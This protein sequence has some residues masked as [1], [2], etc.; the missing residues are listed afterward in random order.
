MDGRPLPQLAAIV[1]LLL[2]G[3]SGLAAGLTITLAM[4]N[5]S[6]V[7]LPGVEIGTG[8]ALYGALTAIAGAGL[9]WRRR[10][11]WWLG[12]ATIAAGGLFLAGLV[13]VVRGDEVFASGILLLAVTLACLLSPATRAS[14]RP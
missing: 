7:P 8:I 14:L 11:A 9:I 6:T 2:I 1:L 13:I 3:C 10:W 12:F 4:T 5:A